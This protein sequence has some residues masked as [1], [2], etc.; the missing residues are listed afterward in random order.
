MTSI[1]ISDNQFSDLLNI[2]HGVFKPIN[3]FVNKDEF[4]SI[5]NH[6]HIRKKFFPLPIY[7]GISKKEYLKIKN[8]KEINL[9]YQ[10]KLIAKINKI[11]FFFVD[12]DNF[13]KRIYGKKFRD[14]PFF[15]I[16]LKK[17]YIFINFKFLKIYRNKLK[18]KLFLKPQKI[19]KRINKFRYSSFHS[20]NVPHL[21]HQWIHNY[22]SSKFEG[23]VIQPMV[24]QYK[25]GEYTNDTIIKMNRLASKYYKKKNIIVIPFFSYPRY[26]GPREAALHAIV[27]RNYGC[28]YFWVGRDHAGI[29]KNFGLYES[30]KFCLKNEK[31]LRIKIIAKKEPY[32]C[33]FQKKVVNKCNCKNNCKIKISGSKIRSLIKSGKNIPPYL[34]SEKISKKL[35]RKSLI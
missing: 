27:R 14:N 7:F 25:K 26:G 4:V 2:V 16:F 6:L 34:M 20:R 23:L 31:K 24:G 21:A 15:K 17:N 5:V 19:I 1:I 12:K 8:K 35:N 22:L 18:H 32:Y 11:N 9:T 28:K 29:Y 10:N 13:G 30:Q 3:N 33:K